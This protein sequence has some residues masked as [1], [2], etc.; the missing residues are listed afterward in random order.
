MKHDK[1]TRN[2]QRDIDTT[3]GIKILDD[4]LALEAPLLLLE[5]IGAMDG[6]T[7]GISV[8][9]RVRGRSDTVAVDRLPC[10]D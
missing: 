8:C 9:K 7:D 6:S 10:I 2:T 1:H 4:E 5:L 3:I